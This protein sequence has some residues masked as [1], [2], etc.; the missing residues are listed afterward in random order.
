MPA[1]RRHSLAS[2]LQHF[3][4]MAT[5][6]SRGRRAEIVDGAWLGQ[7]AIGGALGGLALLAFELALAAMTLGLGFALLPLRMAGGILLGPG[8]VDSSSPA[9]PVVV[10]GA[11]VHLTL[12]AAFGVLFAA[13][14]DR[15]GRRRRRGSTMLLAAAAYGCGLWLVNFYVLAPLA[16]WGW[17]ALTD[18]I[19]QLVA[20]AFVFAPVAGLYLHRVES[21]RRPETVDVITP[22]ER[23]RHAA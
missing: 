9:V 1:S 19:P 16:G 17:F 10:A 18:P 21:R 2:A 8:A 12:S 6:T 15:D 20:H 5:V 14:V 4:V 22:E 7:G 13:I 11:L 23:L 3:T